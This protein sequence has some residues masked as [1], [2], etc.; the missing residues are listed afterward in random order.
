MTTA[1]EHGQGE[2]FADCNV[3]K[4]EAS[5]YFKRFPYFF[6]LLKT[7]SRILYLISASNHI[8]H[9]HHIYFRKEMYVF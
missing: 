8:Y 6:F 7:Y 3:G 4:S 1:Y 5:L 2:L 9:Q